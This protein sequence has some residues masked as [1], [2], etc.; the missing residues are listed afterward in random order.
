MEKWVPS[1]DLTEISEGG[2]FSRIKTVWTTVSSY[3]ASA[4]KST[5]PHY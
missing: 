1:M 5:F 3:E 4:N 2:F